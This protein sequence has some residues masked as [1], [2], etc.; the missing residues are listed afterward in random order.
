[1]THGM[2]QE[3]LS[4][5]DFVGSARWHVHEVNVD[6]LA[7][8]VEMD[9]ASYRASSFLDHRI[10]HPQ[11][12]RHR[13]R[14][15]ELF[16]LF[17]NVAGHETRYIF[18]I[19]HVGSTLLSRIAG[20]AGDVLALREPLLLRWLSEIRR[21]LGK[22]ESRFDQLGYSQRLLATLGILAR[23]FPDETRVVV[24]AT[25]FTNNLANDILTLQPKA[26][27]V[28][29]YCP[30]DIFAAGVLVRDQGGWRDMV[31]QAPSRMARL[32]KA[33]ARQP[34]QL[35]TMSP[36]EVVALNWLT[37]VFTLHRAAKRHAGRVNWLN[38]DRFLNDV[39]TG[40]TVF[41]RSLDLDPDDKMLSRI[42]ASDVFKSYSKNPQVAYTA[43][44]RRARLD[45]ASQSEAHEISRG[46]AWLERVLSD[47]AEFHDLER[48]LVGEAG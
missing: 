15:A 23:P 3:Q 46:R 35:W 45:Q 11:G 29:V 26:Q 4:A 27:A 19:S 6:G 42:N 1:M 34:W 2:A 14:F 22:P 37:E 16:P 31:A 38:F 41:L 43:R 33:I 21:E 39:D 28:A 9:Q 24:K 47:H 48:Y 32:H 8:L 17:P 20:E 36:G 30:Y 44:D 25:S 10:K 5:N 18:H 7:E 12:R 40:L 13:I